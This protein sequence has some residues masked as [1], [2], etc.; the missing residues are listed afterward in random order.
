MLRVKQEP[1]ALPAAEDDGAGK[2]RGRTM[3]KPAARRLLPC[4]AAGRLHA[5][6]GAWLRT[7][8]EARGGFAL[9]ITLFDLNL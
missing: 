4:N 5:M 9:V 6:R 7:I 2:R 1:P 8:I 3:P